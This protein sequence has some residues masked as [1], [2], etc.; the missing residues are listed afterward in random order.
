MR[1]IHYICVFCIVFPALS[2]AAIDSARILEQFKA[3]QQELIFE[4][5]TLL[6]E[7]EREIMNNFRRLSIFSNLSEGV[8]QRRET[9]EDQASRVTTRIQ[10]LEESIAEL[11]SD[12]AALLSEVNR[13]NSQII[14]TKESIE[15]NQR[16]ITLL[17]DKVERSTEV[18]QAYIVHLYK[19]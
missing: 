7:R 4:S 5:D 16:Q 9:L 11:D 18:I 19:K 10:S 13:I 1:Y 12:I 2:Y 8:Q 14:E 6:T 15:R 17:R 3:R